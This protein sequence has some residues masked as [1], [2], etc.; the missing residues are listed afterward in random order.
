MIAVAWSS[1]PRHLL[2]LVE[3]ES[4]LSDGMVRGIFRAAFWLRGSPD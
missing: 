1:W 3:P 4:I 2:K